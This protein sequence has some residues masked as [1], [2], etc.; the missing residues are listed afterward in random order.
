MNQAS[1]PRDR[2]YFI[3][4]SLVAALAG[5]LFGFDTGVIS[6]AILYINQLF[7][8]TPQAN[9]L[10]VSAVLM[11]ALCGSAFSGWLTDHY[12]RKTILI[13][14]ACIFISGTLIT[15]LTPN[16]PILIIG[17]FIVGVAV[18]IASYTAPLYISEIAPPR[19]RGALVSLNQLAIALGIM[20][21]YIVD[22]IFAQTGSW[23]L[24]LGFGILPAVLLFVGMLF[25]PRS[26]RWLVAKGHHAKALAILRRIRGGDRDV[27]REV[28]EIR[29]T[30]REKKLPWH[31]LFSKQIRPVLIIGTG[32]A[33]LQQV[34]GINTLLYYAPTIFSMSGLAGSTA[35][36]FKAMGIGVIFVLF[37]IV[38]I[39]LLDTVGRRKLL[40]IG[41]VGM[42]I[43]LGMMAAGLRHADPSH[44]MQTVLQIG[45]LLYIACF[46]FSLGPVMWLMI[47]EIY[48]LSIRGV[49]A[50]FATCMNWLSN[51][52]VAFSFLSIIQAIGIS[53]TFMI[54]FVMCI[55]SIIFVYFLVPETKGISLERIEA[56]LLENKKWRHLG[57]AS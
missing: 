34:T 47:T 56:N 21:S 41:L 24:M 22:Y 30:L 13:T 5:I 52:I 48:P 40:L 50:S 8:L 2:Y 38:A 25:L 32:L 54:Y 27:D 35:A 28:S 20:I 49:G 31:F 42:A 57:D 17:R 12:G 1:S 29:A 10:V 4:I 3:I 26:P 36:I 16:I 46:S 15:T 44:L 18:G 14:V 45:V 23:R 9:G 43:G 53:S 11:G 19:F 37:T 6:G 51:G 39:P 33:I 55:L 7:H